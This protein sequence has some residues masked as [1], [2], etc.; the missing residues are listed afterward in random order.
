MNCR[1][2]FITVS[3]C[4][5]CSAAGTADFPKRKPG[6]W[7]LT[8]ISPNPKHPARVEKICL[9]AETDALLYKF[10]EGAGHSI[11]SKL[12]IRNSGGTVVVDSVCK[13]GESTMTGHS[14]ITYT[15]TDAYHE[16]INVAYDPPLYGNNEMHMQQEAQW[17][18]ACPA[19]MKPGDILMRAAPTMPEVR[20]NI[21]Q[22]LGNK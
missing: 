3:L 15:G 7:Q 18:G 8:M 19:D 14:V 16:D 17:L 2:M 4:G 11:C 20:M 6:L 9:D 10:G 13:L 12:D 1:M 5:I 21:R 22:M